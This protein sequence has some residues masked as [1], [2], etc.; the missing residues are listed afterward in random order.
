MAGKAEEVEPLRGFLAPDLDLGA[1][2]DVLS[3]SSF[4]SKLWP[5]RLRDCPE[6]AT[7]GAQL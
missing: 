6:R 1:E 2:D 4:L 7:F 5:L 3:H